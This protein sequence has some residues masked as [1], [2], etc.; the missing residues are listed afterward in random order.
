VTAYCRIGVKLIKTD[1]FERGMNP[2]LVAWPKRKSRVGRFLRLIC[3][4]G[5]SL[6]FGY[7]TEQRSSISESKI[8]FAGFIRRP[9]GCKTH[10]A[11]G[12]NHILDFRFAIL[13]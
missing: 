12:L 5:K 8:G 6:C 1:Y 7:C 11:R 10:P 13:D 9:F 2:A 3:C 4:E